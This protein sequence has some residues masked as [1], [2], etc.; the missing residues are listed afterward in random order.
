[1]AHEPVLLFA[2]LA[3]SHP[4]SVAEQVAA[5]RATSPGCHVV[6]FNGGRDPHLFR[7]LDVEECAYRWPIRWGW[8][9]DRYELGVMLHARDR[10]LQ[11][12][13]LVVLD[14][15]MLPVRPGFGAWLDGWLGE[16]SYA[17]AF[18]RTEPP[19]TSHYWTRAL[20]QQRSAWRDVLGPG[21]YAAVFNPCQVF[22][23]EL[24]EAI[25]DG[26]H[27]PRLAGELDRTRLICMEELL[28]PNLVPALGRSSARLPPEQEAA[29]HG[30]HTVEDVERLVS[31]PGVYFVHK[32]PLDVTH[33]VRS[34]LRAALQETTGASATHHASVPRSTAPATST[35][36]DPI[37]WEMRMTPRVRAVEALFAAQAVAW[38]LRP[39]PE[40]ADLRLLFTDEARRRSRQG[41]RPT[42][43]RRG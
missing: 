34:A 4:E 11:Y 14:S 12:D 43:G 39:R 8:G 20:Y 17:A 32:V 5:L 31:D 7:G 25:L 42:W 19:S 29:L 37:Q 18:L 27:V 3:H 10:G 40:V 13:H 36:T 6:A 28:W 22:R 15:D 9:L 41:V 1:M 16:A 38:R 2:L 30:E 33:P 24:V 26:P 35:G 23:R 21:P